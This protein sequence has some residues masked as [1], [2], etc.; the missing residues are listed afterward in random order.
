MNFLCFVKNEEIKLNKIGLETFTKIPVNHKQPTY[1]ESKFMWIAFGSP[2]SRPY[3]S[4]VPT[5]QT[6]KNGTFSVQFRNSDKSVSQHKTPHAFRATKRGQQLSH[7]IYTYDHHCG[8]GG[9]WYSSSP[10]VRS[11][12]RMGVTA[13]PCCCCCWGRCG[14]LGCAPSVSCDLIRAAAEARLCSL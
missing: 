4:H 6:K 13:D 14:L 2:D 8:L 12:G 5:S 11:G 9:V 1:H 10:S 3:T 7:A